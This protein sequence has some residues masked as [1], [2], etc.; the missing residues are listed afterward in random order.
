MEGLGPAVAV[1]IMGLH[2]WLA[3]PSSKMHFPSISPAPRPQLLKTARQAEPLTSQHGPE[4]PCLPR[5]RVGTWGF[6]SQLHTAGDRVQAGRVLLGTPQS[7]ALC[8]LPVPTQAHCS[9]SRPSEGGTQCRHPVTA[10]P[11]GLWS[12]VLPGRPLG[13]SIWPHPGVPCCP[14]A[15]NHC[16]PSPA[17]PGFGATQWGARVQSGLRPWEGQPWWW[18][19]DVWHGLRVLAGRARLAIPSPWS[20]CLWGGQCP[21]CGRPLSAPEDRAAPADPPWVPPAGLPTPCGSVLASRWPSPAWGPP[22]SAGHSVR[23]ASLPSDP[24][25]PD[26][27]SGD[28]HPDLPTTSCPSSGAEVARPGHS[29]QCRGCDQHWGVVS[30]S[31]FLL[32]VLI[33]H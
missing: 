23:V 8:H 13:L 14:Q 6:C 18:V 22:G 21:A 20:A 5:L 33:L 32:V 1:C 9:G 16:T 3:A 15:P 4:T 10:G 25:P 30:V 19:L 31:L 12:P 24:V 26:L 11:L 27:L 28:T 29:R 17:P 7:R 2:L